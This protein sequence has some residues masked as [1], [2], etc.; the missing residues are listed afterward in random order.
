MMGMNM[1]MGIKRLIISAACAVA[2]ILIL[3]LPQ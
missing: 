2:L 3:S 1:D